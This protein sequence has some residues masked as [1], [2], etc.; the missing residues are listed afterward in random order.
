ME[1]DPVTEAVNKGTLYLYKRKCGRCGKVLKR[2]IFDKGN[3][4][5]PKVAYEWVNTPGVDRSK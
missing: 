5:I 2:G 1:V 3:G 4:V